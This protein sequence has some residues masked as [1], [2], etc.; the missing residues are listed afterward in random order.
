MQ[1]SWGSAFQEQRCAA[2]LQSLA[3]GNTKAFT[4]LITSDLGELVTA[5][6]D[7]SDTHSHL[8]LYRR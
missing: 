2:T 4:D 6:A 5:Q 1:L 7:L 3:N 8:Q